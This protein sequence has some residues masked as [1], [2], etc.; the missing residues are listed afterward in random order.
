MAFYDQRIAYG[1]NI[2]TNLLLLDVADPT[3]PASPQPS[4]FTGFIDEYKCLDGHARLMGKTIRVQTLDGLGKG[5][6]CFSFP[7]AFYTSN[8]SGSP[9]W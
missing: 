6:T 9:V 7:N 2:Q 4:P 5:A 8:D 1:D 3:C